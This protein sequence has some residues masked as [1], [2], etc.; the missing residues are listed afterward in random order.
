MYKKITSNMMKLSANVILKFHVILSSKGKDNVTDVPNAFHTIYEN[1]NGKYITMDVRSFMTLEIKDNAW[2]KSK[3]ILITP[4][5]IFQLMTHL[6]KLIANIYKKDSFFV[7]TD[8]KLTVNR[9]KL[10]D[11]TVRATNL[12][13]DQ[14]LI[15]FPAVFYDA[16]DNEYE[17]ASFLMNTSSNQFVIPIDTL[18]SFKYEISQVN[19]MLYTSALLNHYFHTLYD[20]E[21]D[22]KQ[23]EVINNR[24]SVFANRDDSMTP[25]KVEEDS[26][27]GNI[28][29]DKQDP[30]ELLNI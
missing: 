19:F 2:N 4:N 8:G 23:P 28:S 16:D 6:N 5:N 7:T 11:Y 1:N 25:E 24:V 15:M 18:E 22:D 27:G 17:G 3:S 26:T 9:D 14:R 29:N 21:S 30:K 20:K 10:S 12:T 13:G